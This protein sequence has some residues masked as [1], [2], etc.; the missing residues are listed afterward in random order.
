M[1]LLCLLPLLSLV[2]FACREAPSSD[3]TEIMERNTMG[4]YYADW[5]KEW[6]AEFSGETLGY[7]F[8]EGNKF[9]NLKSLKAMVSAPVSDAVW[10]RFVDLKIQENYKRDWNDRIPGY[11]Y[12]AIGACERF[13]WSEKE[14]LAER[15]SRLADPNVSTN[16]K[17]LLEMVAARLQKIYAEEK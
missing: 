5:R 13:K 3:S 12:L 9:G 6:D 7:T 2:L 17:L 14:I 16:Y 11:E 8:G 4:T 15:D 1:K 10:A